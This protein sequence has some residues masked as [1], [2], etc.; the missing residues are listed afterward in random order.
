MCLNTPCVPL[1]VQVGAL[2]LRQLR[3][4]LKSVWSDCYETTPRKTGDNHDGCAFSMS[5]SGSNKVFKSSVLLRCEYALHCTHP[6]AHTTF[7]VAVEGLSS[8]FCLVEQRAVCFRTYTRGTGPAWFANIIPSPWCAPHIAPFAL[9][10]ILTTTVVRR[11]VC[12]PFVR[13][14]TKL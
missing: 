11:A 10:V 12:R 7:R 14:G 6:A 13:K 2:W 5:S 1:S 8:F 3:F 4:P 9:R